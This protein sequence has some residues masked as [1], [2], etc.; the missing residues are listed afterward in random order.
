MR[1][2]LLLDY[3]RNVVYIWLR[4]LFFH[5][6]GYRFTYVSETE[7]D[8][9][10]NFDFK[11]ADSYDRFCRRGSV[12]DATV[13]KGQLAEQDVAGIIGISGIM[14][15][16]SKLKIDTPIPPVW[17]IP[18]NFQQNEGFLARYNYVDDSFTELK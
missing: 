10:E 2:A 3:R 8:E 7:Q 9:D 11:R 16:S 14:Q 5:F 13:E 4:D 1:F 18:Q 15:I 12:E 17:N 6:I